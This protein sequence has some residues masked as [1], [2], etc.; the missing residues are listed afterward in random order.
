VRPQDPVVMRVPAVQKVDEP[1]T[2]PNI[3]VAARHEELPPTPPPAPEIHR[4][5]PADQPAQ[6][7]SFSK[8]E[9]P[10]YV[11]LTPAGNGSGKTATLKNRSARSLDVTVTASN[12]ATG[13]QASIQVTLDAFE[14]T[15]VKGTEFVVEQGDVVTVSSPPYHDREAP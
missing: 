5:V 9:V 7:E 3:T 4:A 11:L 12:A 6:V 15:S 2:T 14:Q 8:L 13:H 1:V 10:V